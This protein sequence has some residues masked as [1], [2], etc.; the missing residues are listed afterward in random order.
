MTYIIWFFVME[1]AYGLIY[2]I[3]II[4]KDLRD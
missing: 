4:P 3:Q 1:V 2:T